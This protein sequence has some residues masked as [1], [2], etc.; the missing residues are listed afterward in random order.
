MS[1]V[2]AM[3]KIWDEGGPLTSVS[4]SRFQEDPSLVVGYDLAFS[5][6]LLRLGAESE[7]DTVAASL[8]PG[9]PDPDATVVDVSRSTPWS[10]ACGHELT[11]AW[12]LTN[13]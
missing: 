6:G 1:V 7:F 13:Q 5:N 12:Q 3:Q 9:P 10:K 4:E 11:W 2:V 8:G